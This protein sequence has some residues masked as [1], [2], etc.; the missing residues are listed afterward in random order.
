MK[1]EKVYELVLGSIVVYVI[2]VACGTAA[3]N[4]RFPLADAG[5]GMASSGNPSGSMMDALGSENAMDAVSDAPS[6]GHAPGDSSVGRILDALT[7]PVTKA[8]ADTQSGSRLKAKWY[9]GSDGSK[10]FVAWRDSQLNVDCSFQTSSDGSIRCFPSTSVA[11]IQPNSFAD[12]ACS[13]PV[14][15]V[16]AT[17]GCPP[18]N[19]NY[20]QDPGSCQR[21]LYQAGSS[22]TTIYTNV[23][24]YADGGVTCTASMPSPAAGFWFYSVG[25]VVDPA[26]FVLATIQTDP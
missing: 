1:A 12:S 18:P 14:S 6:D 9:A 25:A 7:D 24:N 4:Q 13:Q 19:P 22:L 3:D 10:Q 15:Y 5:S 11:I 16:Y 26:T 17:A 8:K 21:K 20:A 2:V 23:T